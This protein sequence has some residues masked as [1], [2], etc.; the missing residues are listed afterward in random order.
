MVLF[1]T[2]LDFPGSHF[3][4]LEKSAEDSVFA[5]HTVQLASEL[6]FD[7]SFL[8]S[9]ARNFPNGLRV[10][11]GTK[12]LEARGLAVA[13]GKRQFS[14]LSKPTS[15]YTRPTPQSQSIV[16]HYQKQMWLGVG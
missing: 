8:S 5:S 10:D 11:G 1:P 4:H 14:G 12:R 9:S 2:T 16:Q 15:S 3:S 6:C 13:G 7:G